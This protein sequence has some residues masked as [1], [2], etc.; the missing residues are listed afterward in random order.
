MSKILKVEPFEP[1]MVNGTRCVPVAYE[2]GFFVPDGW[3]EE[4]TERGID[5]IELEL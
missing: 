4:L 3:Q 2:D 1:F 5:Y